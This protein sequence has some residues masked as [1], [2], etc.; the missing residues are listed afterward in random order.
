MAHKA[1]AACAAG[2]GVFL[3]VVEQNVG[4]PFELRFIAQDE[5]PRLDIVG[6]GQPALKKDRLKRQACIERAAAPV[7]PLPR[8]SGLCLIASG[9]VQKPGDKRASTLT[10]QTLTRPIG[11]I[12]HPAISPAARRTAVKARISTQRRRKS[13]RMQE[14]KRRKTHRRLR[15]R[16]AESRRC[17]AGVLAAET[18]RAM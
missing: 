17:R 8:G 7:K 12:S 2:R 4:A 1:Q 10:R 5:K 9:K 6:K 14:P 16:R 11:E 18:V 13:R 3:C 15:L